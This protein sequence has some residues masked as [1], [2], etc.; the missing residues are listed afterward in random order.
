MESAYYVL[1]MTVIS[2]VYF[3]FSGKLKNLGNVLMSVTDNIFAISVVVAF[4][5]ITT[6]YMFIYKGKKEK[7]TARGKRFEN[8]I[9]LSLN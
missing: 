7:G 2:I 9:L 3:L 8:N 5:I 6:N 1:L 4:I